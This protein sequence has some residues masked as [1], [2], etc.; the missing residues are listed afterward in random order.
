M[1]RYNLY[2]SGYSNDHAGIYQVEFN[3]KEQEF[4][5][6]ST[7]NESVNPIHI[8]IQNNYLFTA[9]EIP[10]VGRVSSF[11]IEKSGALRLVNRIDGPGSGTCDIT[12]GDDVVYAANYGS[13]NIFTVPF[14]EDGNLIEVMSNMDHVGKEP[15][16]HS[17][18]LSKDGEN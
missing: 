10:E 13:G 1:E 6:L 9:N 14:E 12:I 8:L 4:E 7:N 18:I 5:I 16:A 17:T 11:K 2:V 3:P 15:R